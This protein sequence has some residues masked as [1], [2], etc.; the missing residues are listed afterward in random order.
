M[1]FI[2]RKSSGNGSRSGFSEEPKHRVLIVNQMR[3]YRDAVRRDEVL[4]RSGRHLELRSE[5]ARLCPTT[6][7]SGCPYR[8]SDPDVLVM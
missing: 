2:R 8:K 7:A 6:D 5:L 3:T 1:C 4:R